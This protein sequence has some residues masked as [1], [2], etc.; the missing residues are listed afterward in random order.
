MVYY[1]RSK[2]TET[3]QTERKGDKIMREFKHETIIIEKE[4]WEFLK[5]QS[6]T[7]KGFEPLS[8]EQLDKIWK[9]EYE[10]RNGGGEKYP[11]S[12]NEIRIEPDSFALRWDKVKQLLKDNGFKQRQDGYVVEG[13]YL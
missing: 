2:G 8:Q 13:I 1:N 5:N 9:R 4:G 12:E 11:I 6:R 7:L 3:L 10:F